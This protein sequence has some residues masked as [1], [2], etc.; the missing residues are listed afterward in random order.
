[1][2]GIYCYTNIA[3]G[4]KYIGKSINIEKRLESH[5]YRF[6]LENDSGYNTPLHRAFR[7]FGYESFDV[8]I[9][10][11]CTIDELEM[12]ETQYMFSLNT[13]VPNGYNVYRSFAEIGFS[14]SKVPGICPKCGAPMFH[15]AKLCKDCYNNNREAMV[16]CIDEDIYM[17]LVDEILSTSYTRVAKNIGYK[18][19]NSL[20][21]MINKFGFP[22]KKYEMALYYKQKTGED[23]PAIVLQKKKEAERQSNKKPDKRKRVAM[24]TMQGDYVKTYN[25]MAEAKK[26]G[27]P[28]GPISECCRGKRKSVKGYIFKYSE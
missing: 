23:H 14:K 6:Y 18:C 7:E 21:K 13:F 15:T 1:M 25:S 10:Q 17:D 3:N 26:C 4:M 9:L 16:D 20:K 2:V 8:E 12:L 19:S 5:K 11:E 24:Y 27:F 22:S 28:S